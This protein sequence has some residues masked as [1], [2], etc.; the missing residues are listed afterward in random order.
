MVGVHSVNHVAFS[1]PDLDEAQRYY[2]AFGLDAR[3]IGG[4]IDLYSFGHPHCW[5]SVHGS[6]EAK[7]LEYVSYGVYEDDLA[8]MSERVDRH[9]VACKPHPMSDGSGLWLR[10]PDGTTLQLVAA[11]KVSPSAKCAA[12]A[13]TALAPGNGAAP[14]RSQVGPVQPRHLSHVLFYTLD[15]PRMTRFCTELLGLRLSDKSGDGIAFIHG[16]H[17]SD[18][19]LVAFAK[20]QGPGLHH[21]SWDVGS[22]DDV[23]NG[24][25]Q[26]R[27]AGFNRGWG[28]GRHVLGS[29]YFHYVRD[30]WGSYSEYSFDIDFVPADLD[31]PA[32]DHPPEDSFYVWGPVPPE[33][34]VTNFETAQTA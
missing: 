8:A 17:G 30:P 34:F 14:A 21:L 18:H 27:L 32:A 11:P 24:A 28:L 6:G 23:G 1:V 10:N 7:R 16:V 3:R 13:P 19:H 15:V 9:G 31:W 29:N 5:A 4:R 2:T 12:T 33:D 26:M 20:S 22:L 25:E